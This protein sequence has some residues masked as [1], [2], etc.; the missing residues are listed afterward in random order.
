MLKLFGML[1]TFFAVWF[2]PISAVQSEP[3]KGQYVRVELLGEKLNGEPRY[4]SL[5]ELEVFDP[6]CNIAAGCLNIAAG[7]SAT[8]TQASDDTH[9]ASNALNGNPNDFT[10]TWHIENKQRYHWW[11]VDLGSEL[12]ISHLRI[13]NR[14]SCCGERI[15][16]ARVSI[17]DA[18]RNLLWQ[19]TIDT[20]QAQYTF[21][22][23]VKPATPP[24]TLNL[25]LNAAFTKRTNP[26]LPDEWGVHDGFAQNVPD[27]QNLYFVND[28]VAPPVPGVKVVELHNPTGYPYLYFLPTSLVERRPPGKYTFSFYL[29]ADAVQPF[30]IHKGFD[31]FDV[32]KTRETASAEWQ[33]FRTTFAWSGNYRDQGQALDPVIHLPSAGVYHI[34]APQLEEGPEPTAFHLAVEDLSPNPPQY[35]NVDPEILAAANNPPVRPQ[36]GVKSVFETDYYT[37]IDTSAR[38]RIMVSNPTA[39]DV[40]CAAVGGTNIVWSKRNVSVNTFYDLS[41][42]LSSFPVGQKYQCTI[43]GANS[44]VV[45][46]TSEFQ[47]LPPPGRPPTCRSHSRPMAGRS[48]RSRDGHR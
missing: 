9:I 26:E 11:E 35:I 42:S 41:V 45:L 19:G 6:T 21:E 36:P 27:A 1:L 43:Y 23:I 15:N 46:T 13:T 32:E 17:L 37:N 8:Q 38:L 24:Q 10:H 5:A 16:P 40:K 44:A 22:N 12:Q 18:Q 25:L 14:V 29:K 48:P 28:N 34:A 3:V 4:L 33:R 39:I 7:K 31:T 30:W 2:G 47:R 20:T